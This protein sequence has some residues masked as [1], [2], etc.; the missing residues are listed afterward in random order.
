VLSS[1]PSCL[2]PA[3]TCNHFVILRHDLITQRVI[4]GYSDH[5]LTCMAAHLKSQDNVKSVESYFFVVPSPM[6]HHLT[7][8]HCFLC[9]LDDGLVDDESCYCAFLI[10]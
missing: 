1:A 6:P 8:V 5:K 2:L 10:V 7:L 9:Q 3:D 4:I